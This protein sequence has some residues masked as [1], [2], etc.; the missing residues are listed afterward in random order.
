[1]ATSTVNTNKPIIPRGADVRPIDSYNRAKL[2]SG[3]AL[4]FDGVNDDIN[5]T[6][7]PIGA[8]SAVSFSGYLKTTQSFSS[9]KGIISK[10]TNGFGDFVIAGRG[11]DKLGV[12]FQTNSAS[13]GYHL[14]TTSINDGEWYFFTVTWENSSDNLKIYINGSLENTQTIAGDSVKNT[15]TK[16]A[17][18][19]FSNDSNYFDGELAN[20]K[21]FNTAL[22]AAQV[23]DLY[24]NPEKVV[25]TGVANS[26]L[27]L[28]LP[29]QEGA[30]TTAYDGSG[31]GNHGT[32]SGATYT[33]GI[34]APVSQTAVIDWNKG[35]N[36]ATFSEDFSDSDWIALT[37]T[38]ISTS[39]PDP[40]GGSTAV[41]ITWSNGG[42]AYLYQAVAQA[43]AYTISMYVKS[44]G[45]GN[46]FRLFGNGVGQNSSTLTATNEWQRFDFS[47][48]GTGGSSW[49]IRGVSGQ[50]ADLLVAFA[51][52]EA[53]SSVGPY[54]P[55]IA[56][57]Q[58]TPVLLPAGLTTG[59]DITGVNLFE[60]V[61]KQGALNLDG[62]SWAEVHDNASLDMT[63]AITLEA[64]ID[65]TNTYDSI[66]YLFDKSDNSTNGFEFRLFSQTGAQLVFRSLTPI[67]ITASIPS[68]GWVHIVGIYD[69]ANTKIYVNGVI[70]STLSATG[71]ITANNYPLTIGG[72][73]QNSNY[74]LNKP[75]AQ[76]R[77]YNRALTAAEVLNNYNATSSLYI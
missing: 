27:K 61:R 34:G 72:D 24:N 66:R 3:K 40:I 62:K 68:S 42:G 63:S 46:N 17:I 18:G 49:G 20:F 6:P 44:N 19:A 58:P 14:S 75:I 41:N 38:K 2:F 35:T 59:R 32:I 28:W 43:G 7:A 31:N 15:D 57:A 29:M 12:Y 39:E 76:P 8:E 47:F 10:G 37:S 4:D 21:I 69:G 56:T 45:G 48:T 53:N 23:A 71:T 74:S 52:L 55:T 22:T 16:L 26:A 50:A 67:S 65:N 1:M 77:I 60:N 64:W 13:G 33:H 30:G 25:P 9:V 54:V 73:I 5:V 36:L 11:T 70:N 51:Q